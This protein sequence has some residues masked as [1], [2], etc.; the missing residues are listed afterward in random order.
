MSQ[1]VLLVGKVQNMVLPKILLN[2]QKVC[3]MEKE[4][5]I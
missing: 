2:F 5:E 1:N 3:E 4:L